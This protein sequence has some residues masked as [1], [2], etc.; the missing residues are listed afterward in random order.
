[1][2]DLIIKNGEKESYIKVNGNKLE[3]FNVQNGIVSCL[4][5]EEVTIINL[6]K[7][8]EDKSYLGQDN[9][10]DVYL[11]HISGLKHYFKDGVEDFRETW[12]NNGEDALI[13]KSDKL[14][15]FI[16]EVR[17]MPL[18]YKKKTAISIVYL[19]MASSFLGF[20]IHKNCN[21]SKE[22]LVAYLDIA[23]NN[24]SPVTYEQIEQYIL[25]N[26]NLTEEER[27]ITNN[28]K[29]LRDV[30]PYY[31]NTNMSAL[32]H[33]KFADLQVNYFYKESSIVGYYNA[34]KLNRI[35]INE[36][37]N[38]KA[39][40]DCKAHE[41]IHLL[42][43]SY[44][45]LYLKE[46][47][48]ELISYEYYD[49]CVLNSYE[50]PVENLKLLMEIIGPEP[51]WELNFGDNDSKFINI[52]K[53][54]LPQEKALELL[55]L[56][57]KKPDEER[58]F[59]EKITSLLK[60][61]YEKKYNENMEENTIIFN[62]LTKNINNRYYF[63]SDLIEIEAPYKTYNA[64]TFTTF[65]IYTFSNNDIPNIQNDILNEECNELFMLSKKKLQ[66]QTI[67]DLTKEIIDEYGI[68]FYYHGKEIDSNSFDL[69]E[70]ENSTIKWQG[71]IKT[72]NSSV[73][74]KAYF[75]TI[76]ESFPDQRIGEKSLQSKSRS[77]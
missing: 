71:E 32:L 63:N 67:N 47:S 51:I 39:R 43:S 20:Q 27:E 45:Y 7:L 2:F 12:L 64:E 14:H 24:Y 38:E 70:Y 69:T 29:L 15:K 10:Y 9:G 73:E 22:S 50:K 5:E 28:E 53:T 59:N 44:N 46:A 58:E 36:Y 56:L 61:L 54:Y 42:Q 18:K 30:I 6:L 37:H 19:I 76:Y 4:T 75:P 72:Q 77:F 40:Y 33:A 68:I 1:M 16:D 17:N 41:Y 11:D 65:N 8:S 49:K 52:I 55:N 35:Y 3:G 31:E 13:Y 23:L 66:M 62:I 57:K 48:A 26:D 25:E 21:F 74:I 60:E 34:T